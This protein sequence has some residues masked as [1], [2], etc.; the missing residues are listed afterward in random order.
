MKR[1]CFETR[2]LSSFLSGKAHYVRWLSR[3]NGWQSSRTHTFPPPGPPTSR[4]LYLAL[5]A[6][7]CADC[8]GTSFGIFLLDKKPL[9]NICAS[10]KPEYFLII[11]ARAKAHYLLTEAELR[12]LPRARNG[13]GQNRYVYFLEKSVK[14]M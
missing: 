2:R 5:H 4:Q 12:E 1:Q 13:S 9:C 10:C 11:K 14:K 7:K 3:V 8:G 6:P